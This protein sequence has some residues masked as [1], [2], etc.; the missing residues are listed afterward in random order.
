[1][2]V[3][4]ISDARCKVFTAVTI[5]ESFGLRCH[6]DWLVE[7][8]ISEKWRTSSEFISNVKRRTQTECV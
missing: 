5:L 3:N 8:N 2:D 4:F 1:M 6:V 7:A